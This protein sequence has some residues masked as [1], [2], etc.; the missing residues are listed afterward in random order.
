MTPALPLPPPAP[1]PETA[2]PRLGIAEGATR[3]LDH[4]F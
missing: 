4:S 2:H 3:L 1:L